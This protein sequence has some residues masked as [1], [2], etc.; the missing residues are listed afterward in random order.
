MDR[1]LIPHMYRFQLPGIPGIDGFKLFYGSWH[2]LNEALTCFLNNEHYACIACLAASV[3]L[4]LRRTLNSKRKFKQLICQAKK[5]KIISDDEKKM[6]DEL[7]KM[8]NMYIHFDRDSLPWAKSAKTAR[9][10]DRETTFSEIDQLIE[11]QGIKINPYPTDAH[12]DA[13]PLAV[14]API[15]YLYLNSIIE[16]FRKRYPRRDSLIDSYYKFIILKMEGIDEDK[17]FI[18]LEANKKAKVKKINRL[19]ASLRRAFQ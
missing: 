16:F 7:R 6:L 17:V 14:L 2:L 18:K 11:L 15:S 9:I 19:L 5:N 10:K 8:R 12:R 13:I 4:W 1:K 3:E